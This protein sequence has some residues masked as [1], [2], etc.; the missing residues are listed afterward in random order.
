MLWRAGLW[1]QRQGGSSMCISCCFLL[2]GARHW[3]LLLHL[4]LP[5][6]CWAR[7]ETSSLG[8]SLE[9]KGDLRL[10]LPLLTLAES[11]T[12]S[13]E[14]SP[15]PG[16]QA[17]PG[18]QQVPVPSDT[19]VSAPRVAS[20]AVHT[21]YFPPAPDLAVCFSP[22]AEIPVLELLLWWMSKGAVLHCIRSKWIN[23]KYREVEYLFFLLCISVLK[24]VIF[25]KEYLN[26]LKS[27]V[28][29]CSWMEESFAVEF[30]GNMLQSA[31]CNWSSLPFFFLYI[32]LIL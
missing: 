23:I 25:I 19:G 16:A 21:S 28:R 26:D 12:L 3:Q 5:S 9:G 2:L 13:P 30:N 24:C 7:L 22:G 11:E 15:R 14:Q 32:S 6:L 31:I 10:L 4:L 18:P 17:G 29:T 20:K 1:S 8:C 27:S